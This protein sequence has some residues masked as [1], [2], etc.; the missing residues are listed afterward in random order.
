MTR[1][2]APKTEVTLTVEGL[3]A[4]TAYGV[5]VHDHSCA[6]K[7]PGGGHYELDPTAAAGQAN[8]I[9]LNFTSDA[10]GKGTGTA[11]PAHLARPEAG[12]IVIHDP[13]ASRVACIDLL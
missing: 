6:F 9:W 3:K 12:S 1:D 10:S 8:E 7:T 5:H 11:S 13:D 4:S 2:V